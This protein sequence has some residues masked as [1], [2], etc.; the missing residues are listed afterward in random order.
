MV[1]EGISAYRAGRKD[2][3]R[4]LLLRATEIDQYN[5]QAWLWLSAVVESP[6]EARTCLE[7]VLTINPNNERARQGIETLAQRAG[8]AR[9]SSPQAQQQAEDILASASFNPQAKG[10]D[11]DELPTSLEW[12][13]DQ[14]Q[15]AVASSSISMNYKVKEPSKEE[16]DDWVSGLGIGNTGADPFASGGSSTPSANPFGEIDNLFNDDTRLASPDDLFAAGPFSQPEQPPP[17]AAS[18]PAARPAA[19]PPPEKV[20]AEVDEDEPAESPLTRRM[21]AAA[22]K[23]AVKSPADDSLDLLDDLA[24]NNDNL[25]SIDFDSDFDDAD[26]E[27]PEADELFSYIPKG[28]RAT[29][30]PGTREGYPMPVVIGLIGVVL[31]NIAAVALF[32]MNLTR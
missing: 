16:Y 24:N 18:K 8:G 15:S 19:P 10:A 32:I 3:A 6:D 22:G 5:E 4:A 12:G 11:A 14:A 7:N 13:G 20:Y 25:L 21:N 9:P 27:K 28:I 31:L 1:R 23:A 30:L 26:L 29:R 2:E 17:A